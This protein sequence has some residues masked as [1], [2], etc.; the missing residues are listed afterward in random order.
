M[1]HA[2]AYLPRLAVTSKYRND[3]GGTLKPMDELL[4][5]FGYDVVEYDGTFIARAPG[6]R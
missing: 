5:T 2:L 4:R 3:A 6:S 1:K